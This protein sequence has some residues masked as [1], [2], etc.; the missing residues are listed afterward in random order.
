MDKLLEILFLFILCSAGGL[1]QSVRG[2]YTITSSR[3]LRPNSDYHVA[4]SV[5]GTSQPTQVLVEVGGKQGSG[6]T[7]KTSQ[8]TVVAPYSTEIV[9]L[10]I[11]D[12]GP[13]S[14][15]LTARGTGGLEFTNTTELEYIHK[16]YSV[17]I[18]TDKAIYKPGHKVLFR[19][20]VLNAHLKPSVTGSLDIYIADGKGHRVKQWN[21]ALTTKGVFSG[22]LQLAE[23]PVLGDWKIVITVLDQVF[24]KTFQVAEYV[25]PKFEVLIDAPKHATFKDSKV[26]AKIRSKYTYGKPV[27]GEATVTAYPLYYSGFIQPIFETPIRKVVPIDGKAVVDFDIVKELK[28]TDEYERTIQIDVTVEEALTGRRQNTSS[29]LILHKYKYSMELIKT[30]E[31]FKPGLKYTAFLKLAY[32]DG[33]PVVDEKNPVIVKHGFSYDTNNYTAQEYKLPKNGILE[34]NFFVQDPNV[35]TLGIEATYLDYTE[36][37][38]TV[39]SSVSPSHTFL[40]ATLK[41]DKPKVNEDV[42]VE[43]NSTVPLRY[44]NYV[45]LG[46]GDVIYSTTMALNSPTNKHQFHFLATFAMAPTAHVIVYYVTPEGEIVADALNVD[47]DSTLQN[48]VNIDASPSTA[49]PGKTVELSIKAKPNSYVGVLAVDQ[50]VLLLKT[51]NDITHDDVMNELNMYDAGHHSPYSGNNFFRRWKR[52]FFFWPGSATAKKVFDNSGTVL[53]TN[54]WLFDHDPYN[55]LYPVAAYGGGFAVPEA[56]FAAAAAAP[57][58]E[59]EVRIRDNFPETWLWDGF[60][61]GYDGR[62][63]L[64]PIV[65]DTITSWVITGFSVDQVHGLGLMEAPSKVTVFRPF[66]VSLDL[67][68]SVIRGEIVSI[69]VVVFNY[70]DEDLTA[71]VTLK[72]EGEFDFPDLS[73]DVNDSPSNEASRKKSVR[74]KANDG[75]SLSFMIIPKTLGYIS[76]RVTATSKRAGDGV[77]RKLLVKPEGETQ[78]RN[79]AIFVDLR[80]DSELKENVTIDLPNNIVPDSEFI[81]VSA[82][83][84]ILGPSLPNL[85]NLIRMPFGCGEQ[86]ML[87]FVPNI[88]VMDY[89]QNT[90]QLT[91]AIQSKAMKHLETGYQQELSYRR[92]DGSFSAFG[93][94]DPNGST[95]LT[96]FV[97]RSFRQAAPYINIEESVIQDALH[98]LQ[99]NQASNGSFPEVGQVRHSAMQGGSGNGLALTSFTLITFLENQKISPIYRNSI[100]K[101]VDYIVKNLKDL[102]DPFAIAIASYALHLANHPAKD[103]AFHLLEEKAQTDKEGEMKFWKKPIPEGDEKNPWHEAIPNGVSVEMTAYAM[104]TYLERGL[105]QDAIPIMKWMTSQR[106]EQG[107]FASTQDTV[108][109]LYALSKLG[110]QISSPNVDIQV[111]FGYTAGSKAQTTI[112]VNQQ[113]AMIVQ[114]TQLPRKVREVEVTAK[115][116]GIA[117]VQVSYKYNLNV[118]GAWPLFTLDPQV[119]KN[120]DSN[121]LQVS[122]CSGFVGT[123][124]TNESNMAVMEVSLPSGFVVDVDSLPSLRVSQNVKRVETKEGD[125]VV[126]L[127]FDKLIKKGVLS[128]DLRVQDAQ[129]RQAETGAG[130]SV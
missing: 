92:D 116:R 112:N 121:H 73:N 129:G 89:L 32:H 11:G 44:Y 52:S 46:R 37:F 14:Y 97:V 124:E 42:V 74:V 24:T 28:L 12:L 85:E 17:F 120:S 43:V 117:I 104:L 10:E 105:I 3:A 127:Y 67:P 109:G 96:A 39:G 114:K 99:N 2:Y 19:A 5:Q 83:G 118:T 58:P 23:Y 91:A 103:Q 30:A 36:W 13:G 56:A 20:I 22:E 95:W 84:D 125:T 81:E 88:V 34:L 50:S 65:P 108:V 41:T 35:T 40:Q 66:F 100:D 102:D 78:Y 57:A 6:G 63:I 69:P 101:A 68:Y 107:G 119:D 61:I 70:F 7:F 31:C 59:T 62:A 93:K 55:F 47:F 4:V 128:D 79:K 71:E 87:N 130:D 15:N 113:K 26:V 122:I 38:S 27:K 9:K 25:L 18:Q 82:V 77:D 29:Q 45:V 90:R 115:G 106:N 8:V 111:S 94:F 80:T 126:V 21:R 49:E 54:G 123:K 1:S 86:N 51:G 72:N 53:L 16:S 110:Q 33:T 64:K 48:F 60:D 76:I 98:W 75:A